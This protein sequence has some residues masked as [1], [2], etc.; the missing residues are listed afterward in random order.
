MVPTSRRIVDGSDRVGNG[1]GEIL[2]YR[3]FGGQVA[4][5][6]RIDFIQ[7]T[8]DRLLLLLVGFLGARQLAFLAA[9]V[10]QRQE[11]NAHQGG[12]RRNQ[13]D[14]AVRE[15]ATQIDVVIRL[16]KIFA[17]F[18]KNRGIERNRASAWLTSNRLVGHQ[19]ILIS[20]RTAQ[21]AARQR[22]RSSSAGELTADTFN[23]I[24]FQSVQH[25]ENTAV[26]RDRA[27]LRHRFR[28]GDHW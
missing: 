28:H 5:R 24:A 21:T 1:A 2:G 17:V 23:S 8:H 14:V 25:R 9:E 11:E 15:D 16:V 26:S 6:Q 4:V 22:Q 12:D 10:K 18:K 19:T 7:K 3:G 13:C 27:P 20:F